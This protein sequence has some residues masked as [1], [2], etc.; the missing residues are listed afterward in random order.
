MN[1]PT[2]ARAAEKALSI[3]IANIEM[4]I[5]TNQDRVDFLRSK[6]DELS[7][8]LQTGT[9]SWAVMGTIDEV[10]NAVEGKR[11]VLFN[12]DGS[13]SAYK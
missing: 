5:R 8:S 10:R 6:R 4:E 11:P 1:T 7:E 3:M 12:F 2:E 13:F 9:P